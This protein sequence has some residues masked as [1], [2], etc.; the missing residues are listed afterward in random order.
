MVKGE[1]VSA[2]MGQFLIVCEHLAEVNK[3]PYD[4]HLCLIT[5]LALG[6]VEAFTKPFKLISNLALEWIT[7]VGKCH[8]LMIVLPC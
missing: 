2:I 8:L 1:N 7:W 3:L 4:A 6:S 5:G